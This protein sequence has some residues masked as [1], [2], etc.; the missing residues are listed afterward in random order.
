MK[1]AKKIFKGKELELEAISDSWIGHIYTS[2]LSGLKNAKKA[3]PHLLNSVELSE[4]I[5]PKNPANKDVFERAKKEL[6]KVRDFIEKEEQAALEKK[7]AE[8]MAKI[9]PDLDVIIEKYNK[10]K[11]EFL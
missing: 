5:F 11:R 10:G 9:K 4:A 8:D 6:Q 2:G 7:Q 3:R 1:R